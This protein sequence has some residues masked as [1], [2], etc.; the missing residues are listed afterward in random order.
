MDRPVMSIQIV[1]DL[2]LERPKNYDKFTIPPKAPYLALLGDVGHVVAHKQD[3]FDFLTRHLSKFKAILFVP[4]HHEAFKSTWVQTL[5]TL[6]GFEQHIKQTPSLGEFVVLDRGTYRPPG[7][8]T[9]ILGCSLFSHVSALE[10]QMVELSV[11]DFHLIENW[12][13]EDHNN[14]HQRH[15]VWLNEQVARLE[16]DAEVA[17]IIILTHWCPTRAPGAVDPKQVESAVS[18][19]YY[20]DLAGQRC[21]DS[22]KVKVWAFGH[23]HYNCD[24]E[25]ERRGGAGN[26]RLVANQRGYYFAQ[27]YHF[28]IWK[29][30]EL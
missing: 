19:A 6:R 27:S 5:K 10:R 7:C 17:R 11:D 21:F 14:A 8:D 16:D 9:V 12:S 23:T 1:S 18:S 4:G 20:N 25:L 15:L 30:I 2:H 26:L 24:V 22:A 3:F 29:T 28:N 13:F